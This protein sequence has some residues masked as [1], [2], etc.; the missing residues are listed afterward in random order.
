MELYHLADIQQWMSRKFLNCKDDKTNMIYLAL[1]H[2]YESSI[3]INITGWR[4][5]IYKISLKL[6]SD[7]YINTNV[8]ITSVFRVA[9]Y[10]IKDIHCLKPFSTSPI[11]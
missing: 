9:Y 2:Y 11:E 6:I 10:N 8:R 5:F 4:V 7:K 3:N 1:P